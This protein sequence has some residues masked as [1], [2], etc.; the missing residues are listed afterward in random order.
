MISLPALFIY[1]FTLETARQLWINQDQN[2]PT[3]TLTE[4]VVSNAG[5]IPL[6]ATS[7]IVGVAPLATGLLGIGKCSL[8]F[9]YFRAHMCCARILVVVYVEVYLRAT[10]GLGYEI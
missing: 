10:I 9:T 3:R 5:G 6:L 4:T 8:T 2:T 7:G 1:V